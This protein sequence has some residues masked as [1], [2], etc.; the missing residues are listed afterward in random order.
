MVVPNLAEERPSYWLDPERLSDP[1]AE[2]ASSKDRQGCAG[3]SDLEVAMPW[4]AAT[5]HQA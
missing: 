3:Y 2:A 1:P 5:G 4:S